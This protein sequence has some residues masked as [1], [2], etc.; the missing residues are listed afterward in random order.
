[1]S[2]ADR[3]RRRSRTRLKSPCEGEASSGGSMSIITSGAGLRALVGFDFFVCFAIERA[4]RRLS[5]RCFPWASQSQVL[6]R[7]VVRNLSQVFVF[8]GAGCPTWSAPDT[9]VAVR[10]A[11]GGSGGRLEAFY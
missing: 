6:G 1:M 7:F 8:I 4:T 9:A 10:P 2:A 3:W 5:V 11:P